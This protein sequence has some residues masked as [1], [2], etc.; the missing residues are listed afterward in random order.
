M[1]RAT[2]V[3][4][5]YIQLGIGKSFRLTWKSNQGSSYL[6]S[7]STL[8]L[9]Q[10]AN[11]NVIKLGF[12]ID[13]DLV[14]PYL[15]TILFLGCFL[16]IT[17][18]QTQNKNMISKIGN[19]EEVIIKAFSELLATISVDSDVES[20]LDINLELEVKPESEVNSESV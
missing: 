15:Q 4:S 8:P 5:Y 11:C 6:E 7:S 3:L 16:L 1:F 19:I 9:D 2:Y 20:E 13:D 10:S 18:S 14:E 12:L 17:I